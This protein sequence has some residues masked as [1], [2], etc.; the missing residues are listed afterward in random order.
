M[1]WYL[2]LVAENKGGLKIF[3]EEVEAL[4]KSGNNGH[5]LR[6]HDNDSEINQRATRG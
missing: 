2:N 4:D 6:S 5:C 3:W 1:M